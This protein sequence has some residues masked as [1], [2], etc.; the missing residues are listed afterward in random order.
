M[1]YYFEPEDIAFLSQLLLYADPGDGK[2]A[3]MH[4]RLS[5]MLDDYYHHD[6]MAFLLREKE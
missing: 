4:R 3:R 6:I 2:Y 1:N 5:E